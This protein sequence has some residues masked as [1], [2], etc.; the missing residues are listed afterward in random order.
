MAVVIIHP[1]S[2]LSIFNYYRIVSHYAETANVV[3]FCRSDFKE[4]IISLYRRYPDNITFEYIDLDDFTVAMLSTTIERYMT[5]VDL[6]IKGYEEFDALRRINDEYF[7]FYA[8]NSF[9]TIDDSYANDFTTTL[10]PVE[11]NLK[12]FFRE[13]NHILNEQ[14]Y[15]RKIK[16]FY[17]PS[18]SLITNDSYVS[19]SNV[20]GENAINLLTLFPKNKDI[21]NLLD[22]ILNSNMFFVG[23]DDVLAAILYAF[24]HLDEF[25][26]LQYK[27][28]Y[29]KNSL[30]GYPE[31]TTNKPT[32]WIIYN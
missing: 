8:L 11:D 3:V 22:V 14:T 15:T 26:S 1:Q 25:K 9:T 6:A 17:V 23:G 7:N 21:L 18:Y 13:P 12:T 28:V 2:Y 27:Y 30:Q 5:N 16:K 10:I 19:K 24:R 31:Y 29:L 20:T 4:S 32:R